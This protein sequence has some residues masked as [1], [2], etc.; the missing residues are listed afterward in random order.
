MSADTISN[1]IEPI[2]TVIK[3]VVQTLEEDDYWTSVK[4]IDNYS[5]DEVYNVLPTLQPPS[6]VVVYKGGQYQNQPRCKRMFSIFVSERNIVDKNDAE[7]CMSATVTKVIGL[8]DHNIALDV[9]DDDSATTAL[10]RVRRDTF[11]PLKWSN[12]TAYEIS[13]EI[14]DY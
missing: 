14:E 13:F 7:T 1:F 9:D 6:A 5:W 2:N 3:W 10:I 12:L 11:I 4:R 8:L